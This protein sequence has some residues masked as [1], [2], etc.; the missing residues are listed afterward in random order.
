[1]TQSQSSWIHQT[2]VLLLLLLIHSVLTPQ[3][4]VCTPVPHG[5]LLWQLMLIF[6]RCA[7]RLSASILPFILCESITA[8]K[9]DAVVHRHIRI[10]PTPATFPDTCSKKH[11]GT[12]LNR[13]TKTAAYSSV[14]KVYTHV[15]STYS[16]FILHNL[17]LTK[18]P[19]CKVFCVLSGPSGRW[20]NASEGTYPTDTLDLIWLNQL[21][22]LAYPH[23]SHCKGREKNNSCQLPI[24][25]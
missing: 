16:S 23:N 19:H 14:N 1:M 18:R 21:V 24:T 5:L 20:D 2:A 25:Q 15:H 22:V 12:H 3:H 6:F 13:Q 17:K 11:T 10:I 8:T 4:R 9:Q 7:A